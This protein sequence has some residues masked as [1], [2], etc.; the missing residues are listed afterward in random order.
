MGYCKFGFFR[1][2]LPLFYGT[3]QFIS[4][5]NFVIIYFPFFAI[6]ACEIVLDCGVVILAERWNQKIL[7]MNSLLLLED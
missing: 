3:S 4:I 1:L 6:L 5:Y 2:F 7:W